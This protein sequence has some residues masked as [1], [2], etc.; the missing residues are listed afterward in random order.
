MRSVLWWRWWWEVV[1]ANQCSST[2]LQSVY[3]VSS[4]TTSFL[5]SHWIKIIISLFLKGGE[6][7]KL[8]CH[9]FNT[10]FFFSYSE[11]QTDTFIA[12]CNN[13]PKKLYCTNIRFSIVI[14]WI[15]M[16]LQLWIWYKFWFNSSKLKSFVI[17]QV[18]I[19]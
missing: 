3:I 18:L 8:Y 17:L 4:T 6:I 5:E 7:L 10:W 2:V 13:C 12:V 19:P 1:C 15:L 14:L 16:W 9:K 11:S